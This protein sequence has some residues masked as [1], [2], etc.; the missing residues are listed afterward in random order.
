MTISPLYL[1]HISP[2]SPAYLPYISLYLH[3]TKALVKE[4]L[5]EI[6]AHTAGFHVIEQVSEPYPY[7]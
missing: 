2:I 4:W 6:A 7:P 3:Y 1:P 5:L